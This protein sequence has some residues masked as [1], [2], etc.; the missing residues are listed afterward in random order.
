MGPSRMA[1]VVNLGG[2]G[3]WQPDQRGRRSAPA[4]ARALADPTG[5]VDREETKPFGYPPFAIRHSSLATHDS[6][7]TFSCLVLLTVLLL[8]LPAAACRYNVRDLGFLDLESEGYQLCIGL[9]TDPGAPAE[10]VLRKAAEESLRDTNLRVA[11]VG[12]AERDAPARSLAG[13]ATN[14]LPAAVLVSP[15]GPT[16]AVPLSGTGEALLASLPSSL[17]ALVDSPLR[18]EL[19]RATSRQFGA[20]LLLEGTDAA[21]TAAARQAATAA[22]AEVRQSLA[23]LPKPITEPPAIVTLGLAAFAR[24]RVLLWS[25]RLTTEPT[26]E[27]RAAVIY[28]KARWLGPL[29]KGPEINVANLTRL[30]SVVGADC[31]C[32]MDLSWTRGT[33]LPVRWSGAVHQAAVKTL[34]FDPQD[35]LV[36]T[37]AGR[38][39]D[40]Y[41]STSAGSVRPTERPGA[42]RDEATRRLAPSGADAAGGLV[43]A[44]TAVAAPPSLSSLWL[45]LGILALATLGVCLLLWQ[46]A[47][48]R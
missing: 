14:R 13:L 25:L 3:C 19:V 1:P 44:T 43:A 37:E 6:R 7:L 2:P 46:R 16:L 10:A 20:I 33:S 11:F 28:G 27:P 23:G 9:E 38:I 31:E 40:R 21:Q 41:S 24:E 42:P 35:P 15:D 45:V 18:E 48:R 4:A 17:K 12:G 36:Q 30:F 39:L 32:G 26:P 5:T 34:G 22:L 29:M 8:S 47:R